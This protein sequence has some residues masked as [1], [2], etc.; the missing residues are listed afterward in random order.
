VK[1]KNKSVRPKK[2]TLRILSKPPVVVGLKQQPLLPIC[3]EA[4]GECGTSGLLPPERISIHSAVG[5]KNKL[6]LDAPLFKEALI[7]LLEDAAQRCDR[8]STIDLSVSSKGMHC[9]RLII[10]YLH[11]RTEIEPR[12]D[13]FEMRYYFHDRTREII[14]QHQAAMSMVRDRRK[15]TIELCFP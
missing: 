2:R 8:G 15:V 12:D 6:W 10:S 14:S 13:R 9:C 11:K 5:V 1:S 4:I 3:F 7:D